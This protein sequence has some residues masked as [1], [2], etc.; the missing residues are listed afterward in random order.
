M[1]TGMGSIDFSNYSILVADDHESVARTIERLLSSLWECNVSSVYDGDSVL[2]ELKRGLE[3]KRY[4]V[5]ITDM[6]MPGTYGTELIRKALEI[7]P[8]L[9]ILVITAYKDEFSLVDVVNAGAL[10]ILIKPFSR[11]ELQA[12]LLR[13]FREIAYIRRCRYSEKRYRELF[14]IY[15]DAILVISPSNLLIKD[16]N[17]SVTEIFGIG[18]DKIIEKPFTEL[19]HPNDVE[20][21][22]KWFNLFMKESQ[23]GTI[24]DVQICV[25]GDE[26]RHFDISCSYLKTEK[27]ED[28]FLILKDVTER[29]KMEDTIIELAQKDELTGL[30]NKRSFEIQLEIIIK[31]A[32]ESFFN[33]A[34]L[35]MDLDNFKNCNDSYG[36]TVGDKLL[37]NLGRII[38]RCIRGSDVGFRFGGDEFAVVLC[39]TESSI[40][41]KVAER[42]KSQ[43]EKIETYG[44]TLSIGIAQYKLGMTSEEWVKL[45]DNAL[46]IAKS[47]GKNTIYCI[48]PE[49]KVEPLNEILRV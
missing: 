32:E 2:I 19:V 41:I 35:M 3:K 6:I 25:K 26:N 22:K 44:T 34:L 18:I 45:A 43:F 11:D 13:I 47:K 31:S 27:G 38:S 37:S 21:V 49:D 24:S 14:D 5:L 28:L 1:F 17:R 20:R 39:G 15:A 36:H 29:K 9:A 30:Y 10:D 33:Y 46:Y 8:D 40:S 4:D 7:D 23:K 42:I 12:K 48:N 16:V